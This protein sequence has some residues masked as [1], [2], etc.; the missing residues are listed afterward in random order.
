MTSTRETSA[1][2]GIFG[3]RFPIYRAASLTG[4]LEEASK[5]IEGKGCVTLFGAKGHTYKWREF[6]EYVLPKVRALAEYIDGGDDF[7]GKAFLYRLLALARG[8]EK[9]SKLDIARCA[10]LLARA[11]PKEQERKE[12]YAEFS[13]NVMSWMTDTAERARFITAIY[14][15]VYLVRQRSEKIAEL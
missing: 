9:N 15:Y 8:A 4:E 10:Y 2:I 12:K 14:L 1:R 3:E 7:R 13:N 6:R 5:S 11:E